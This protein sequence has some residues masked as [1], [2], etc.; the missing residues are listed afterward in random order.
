[1]SDKIKPVYPD[2]DGNHH[3]TLAKAKKA[4]RL[5]DAFDAIDGVDLHH[6]TMGL[7]A[8]DPDVVSGASGTIEYARA[9]VAIYGMKDKA[10]KAEEAK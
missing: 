10:P 9:V 7:A 5:I 3:N 2:S 4:N 1:M 6:A 8:G